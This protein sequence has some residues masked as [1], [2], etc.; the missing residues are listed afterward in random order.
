[1]DKMRMINLRIVRTLETGFHHNQQSKSLQNSK[2]HVL[3][4]P[5]SSAD[6]FNCVEDSSSQ[7]PRMIL[8]EPAPAAASKKSKRLPEQI[9]KDEHIMI[10]QK[11]VAEL[12]MSL[13]SLKLIR[14]GSEETMSDGTIK[15]STL[16]KEENWDHTAV[17]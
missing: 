8:E 13:Q 9:D 2:D 15:T 10:L 7:K 5:E 4:L 3:K 6:A 14:N 11:Q 16:S 1:M 17:V 12:T